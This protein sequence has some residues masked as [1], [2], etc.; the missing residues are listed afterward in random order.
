MGPSRWRVG[1]DGDWLLLLLLLSPAQMSSRPPPSR[2]V[3]SNERPG[4]TR[5]PSVP[6]G[7]HKP[8]K[9]KVDLS[10]LAGAGT[11]SPKASQ[12]NWAPT[13]QPQRARVQFTTDH[14]AS[15]PITPTNS[16]SRAPTRPSS[17]QSSVFPSHASTTY[18]ATLSPQ[19]GRSPSPTRPRSPTNRNH[20]PTTA[21]HPS[22]LAHSGGSNLGRGY[23]DGFPSTLN[24]LPSSV[25][26]R[27]PP[28]KERRSNSPVN[29]ISA[30][31]VASPGLISAF[32]SISNPTGSTRRPAFVNGTGRKVS[33]GSE[34]PLLPP[35]AIPTNHRSV[36]APSLATPRAAT[37]PHASV[38]SPTLAPPPSSYF[39]TASTSAQSSSR[40]TPK[41]SRPPSVASTHA[42]QSHRRSNSVSSA[43]SGLSPSE[44]A[45][46]TAGTSRAGSKGGAR[47]SQSPTFDLEA[48]WPTPEQEAQI[49]RQKEED[50]ERRE[51]DDR[52]KEAKVQRKVSRAPR[53][54]PAWRPHG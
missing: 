35:H 14:S 34:S 24:H 37:L 40:P 6:A 11:Q 8:L 5:S 53:R 18:G 4:P 29:Q 7:T 49:R 2:K 43:T 13:T 23:T 15:A 45:T 50:E 33:G 26:T 48:E 12:L 17:S 31:L 38:R 28:P 10:S 20:A 36:G 54:E 41:P 46:S 32:E 42:R 51:T 9:A 25:T 30:Q 19:I 21:F 16:L 3:L 1:A 52:E 47:Y 22:G 39:P 44:E 27:S